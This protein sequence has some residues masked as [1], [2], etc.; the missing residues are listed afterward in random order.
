MR[1][2]SSRLLP[3]SRMVLLAGSTK[4]FFSLDRSTTNP[5]FG[6]IAGN[7]DLARGRYISYNIVG[8]NFA[9]KRGLYETE[10]CE[11]RS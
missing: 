10:T 8:S 9:A 4:R 5:L 6:L 11:G 2:G 7:F 3:R 1:H